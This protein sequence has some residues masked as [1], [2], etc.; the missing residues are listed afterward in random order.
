MVWELREGPTTTVTLTFWTEP[1]NAF[2]RIREVGRSRW[3]RRRWAKALDRMRDLI[4]T[5]AETPRTEA[6]GGDRLPSAV[7]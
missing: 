2:D 5:G 1:A 4:E 3:W 7:A 6:A